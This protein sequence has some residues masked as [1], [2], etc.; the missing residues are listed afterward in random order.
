MQ[1]NTQVCTQQPTWCH[2]PA[3]WKLSQHQ[4]DNLQHHNSKFSF[5]LLSSFSLGFKVTLPAQSDAGGKVSI[6][7]L[8]VSVIIRE[9]VHMTMCLI[10]NGYR[11]TA[12]WISRHN[13]VRFCSWGSM[14]SKVYKWKVDTWDEMF[15]V[16]SDLLPAY[17][18]MMINLD[19]QHTILHTTCEVLW[20][21]WWTVWTFIVNCNKFVI[22][23]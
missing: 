16:I 2:I 12:V 17:R 11:D 7:E 6:W 19:K 1:N 20:G 22:Y 9:K 8:T 5:I 4:H 13:Y 10:L 18:S 3:H 23:V 21:W 14:K 15:A